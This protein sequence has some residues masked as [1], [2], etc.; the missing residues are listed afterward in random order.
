MRSLPATT[1][2]WI[3]AT[4]FGSARNGFGWAHASSSSTMSS[5]PPRIAATSGV[6]CSAGAAWS[7]SAPHRRHA[8]TTG[9]LPLTTATTSGVK[10]VNDTELM[11]YLFWV[12]GVGWLVG[13]LVG[14]VNDDGGAV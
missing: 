4:P 11:L 5:C 13:W 3:G 12:G 1:A 14:G 10:P 8:R 7:M 2:A 6:H 9:M